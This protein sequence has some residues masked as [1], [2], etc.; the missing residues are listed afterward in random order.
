M[1]VGSQPERD[2]ALQKAGAPIA[3][4]VPVKRRGCRQLAQ[5]VVRFHPEVVFQVPVHFEFETLAC[6]TPLTALSEAGEVLAVV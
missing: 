6:E 1:I 4:V 3:A 2:E 5:I